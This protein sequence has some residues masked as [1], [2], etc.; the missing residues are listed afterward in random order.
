MLVSSS[1][2]C[3]GAFSIGLSTANL[4]PEAIILRNVLI[5]LSQKCNIRLG[6]KT[7]ETRRRNNIPGAFAFRLRK[8]TSDRLRKQPAQVVQQRRATQNFCSSSSGRDRPQ[9]ACT[10]LGSCQR[11]KFDI[12]GKVETVSV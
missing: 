9:T 5:Y 10:L 4:T 12:M 6:D 7:R 3:I 11:G 1:K 2:W 8:C